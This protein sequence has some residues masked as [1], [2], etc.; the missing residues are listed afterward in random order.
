MRSSMK[1]LRDLSIFFFP[2]LICFQLEAQIRRDL[3]VGDRLPD[4]E[5]KYILNSPHSIKSIKTS[6]FKRKAF[7][8]YFWAPWCAPCLKTFPKLDS[9]QLRFK[10]RLQILSITKESR[11][12]SSKVLTNV[13]NTIDDSPMTIVVEDS[14]FH[15]FFNPRVIPHCVWVDS[16][17]IIRAVTGAEDVTEGNIRK[18]TMGE[19]LT[20]K[21]KTDSIQIEGNKPLFASHQVKV[22]ADEMLYNSVLTK[23]VQGVGAAA[24]RGD[25]WISCT[26]HSISRLYQIAFGKFQLAFLSKSRTVLRGFTS[27]EDSLMVGYFSPTSKKAWDEK[28]YQHIY[29]YELIVTDSFFQKQLFQLMQQEL[30]RYFASKGI[31]GKLE[32]TKVKTLGL[33]RISNVDKIRSKGGARKTE[34]GKSYIK[35][36][37]MPLQHL[38]ATLQ[39]LYPKEGQL[40][41][42]DETN[43]K[44]RVDLTIEADPTNID[45]LNAELQKY[46]LKLIEMEKEIDILVITKRQV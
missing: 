36:T 31:E 13:R 1:R 23:Y 44:M 28:K 46:D 15:R 11:G 42:T 3:T 45:Q 20:L 30:N 10:D 14:S 18:L 43:Y 2:V 32:K 7:L 17:G 40:P 6:H 27:V 34:H 9:L 22:S 33:V 35:I 29:N 24:K 19:P 5:L 21:T 12:F 39:V 16:E 41:I 37:N 4:I 26:G 25:N 8:L 38:V